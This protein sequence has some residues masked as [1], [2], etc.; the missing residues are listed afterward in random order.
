MAPGTRDQRST[1]SPG[2]GPSQ[3]T[4]PRGLVPVSKEVVPSVAMATVPVEN[5]SAPRTELFLAHW[6]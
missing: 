1:L 5:P 3:A 4:S 2:S 6:G